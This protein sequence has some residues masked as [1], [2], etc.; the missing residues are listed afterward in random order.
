MDDGYASVTKNRGP[1]ENYYSEK[2]LIV[3]RV[4][5]MSSKIF[6]NYNLLETYKTFFRLL[7]KND[8]WS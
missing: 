3:Q 5:Y 4:L 8:P 1:T 7:L 6:R 2:N